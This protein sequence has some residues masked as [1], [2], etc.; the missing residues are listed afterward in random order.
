[1][2]IIHIEVNRAMAAGFKEIL[3]AAQY[4]QTGQSAE[5]HVIWLTTP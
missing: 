2:G 5:Q 1:M 3:E 4:K